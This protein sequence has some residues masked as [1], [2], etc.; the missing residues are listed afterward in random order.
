MR[1]VIAIRIWSPLQGRP[2]N[3]GLSNLFQSP[4]GTNAAAVREE[5]A[6]RVLLQFQRGSVECAIKCAPLSRHKGHPDAIASSPSKARSTAHAGNAAATGSAKYLSFGPPLDGFDQVPR[7]SQAV[8]GDRSADRRHLIEPVQGEGGVRA[9]I[10][11]FRRC[12]SSATTT[13]CC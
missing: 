11:F 10:S 12:A 4:D 13:A 7:R 5:F 1:S 8:R 2:P 9:P 3:S 6:I